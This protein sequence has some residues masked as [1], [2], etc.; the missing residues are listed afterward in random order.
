LNWGNVCL[1]TDFPYCENV[2]IKLSL[3]ETR[4]INIRV[5]VPF[6][7]TGEM[8]ISINGVVSTTGQP[9]S[10]VSLDKRWYDGDVITF[11]IPTGFRTIKYTGLDRAA[12]GL[13]RYALLY[14]PILMALQGP[15]EGASDIPCIRTTL[16]KLTSLLVPIEGKPLVYDIKN[17]PNYRYLPYS[18]IDQKTFTCFPIVNE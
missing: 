3:R 5:R 4:C 9:G 2:S 16:Q 11:I 8:G 17:M 1:Q 12:N 18:Q 7:A 6:W 13:E 10:Y 15:V 14:G